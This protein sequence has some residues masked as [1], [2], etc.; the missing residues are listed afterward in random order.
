MG[1]GGG[2][3]AFEKT[4]GFG[5]INRKTFKNRYANC[6]HASTL[7]EYW[8]NM[9]QIS[10]SCACSYLHHATHQS[11]RKSKPIIIVNAGDTAKFY[12]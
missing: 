7:P 9:L 3:F 11:F 6:V 12:I 2:V 1:V 8:Y 10:D 4:M 5:S